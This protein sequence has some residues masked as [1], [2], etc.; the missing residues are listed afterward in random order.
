V[1]GRR[2]TGRIVI[3]SGDEKF[4]R[5]AR[6]LL[7]RGGFDVDSTKRI[8]RIPDLVEGHGPDIAVIDA[9]SS[10]GDAARAVAAIEALH[11]DVHIILVC[12]GE[13]P[14]WTSGLK[15]TEKWEALQTL[16]DDIRQLSESATPAW[17]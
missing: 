12:D 9:S 7:T 13:P 1:N 10:L 6:F 4:L 14:R 16:P 5:L 17:S 11:P 2:P 15:V 8:A 3:G